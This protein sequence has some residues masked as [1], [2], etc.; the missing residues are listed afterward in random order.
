MTDEIAHRSTIMKVEPDWI[1]YNGH[2]NMA[3]YA[4]LFDRAIDEIIETWGMGPDYTARDKASIFT[5]E[6]HL[7]YL[8]EL[9]VGEQVMVRS[10]LLDFDAKRTHFFQELHV[11]RDNALSA[12]CE[13]L[14]MHIDM[15]TKRSSPFPGPVLEKIAAMHERHSTLPVK[16]QVGHVMSIPKPQ[17]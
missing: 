17:G 13:Q 9:H 2:L 10:Q 3:F 4:V 15:T 16:P 7:T 1:D 11:V 14:H 6:A 12:A 8:R 5:L